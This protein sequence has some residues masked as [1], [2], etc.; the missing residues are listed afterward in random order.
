MGEVWHARDIT[1]LRAVAVK[2]LRS[3]FTDDDTFL[4][5][6]RVEAQNMASL[7]HLNIAHVHDYGEAMAEG[8]HV[9][10]LVM[11][12]VDGQ[13]LSAIL[14]GQERPDTRRVLDILGQTAAGLGAAHSSGVVH[15]D[16]KPGN[17]I[18]RPDGTVK[19]T[20]FG[21]SRATD[22]VPLTRSGMVVGTA[23]YLS[24]EQAMGRAV[25]PASDVYAL[26]V[27]GYECLAGH[28]PFQA[29]SSVAV[30]LAHVNQDPPPLPNEIPSVIRALVLRAMSK[31]PADRF[32][33]GDA[34][35]AA[36]QTV[37]DEQ[38]SLT[39]VNRDPV[40]VPPSEADVP[41]ADDMAAPLADE[42][43]TAEM[44]AVLAALTSSR[45]TD[46]D[47]PPALSALSRDKPRHR[48]RL[49]VLALV[50]ALLVAGAVTFMV[51]KQPEGAANASG[52]PTSTGPELVLVDTAAYV[53]RPIDE[54]EAE[55]TALGLVVVR[56]PVEVSGQVLQA[57]GL[58]DQPFAQ[59]AVLGTDPAQAEVPP[60]T[61]VTVSFAAQA[62][63]PRG[64]IGSGGGGADNS[65][66]TP[67]P[68]ATQT[69][70]QTQT[71]RPRPHPTRTPP[72]APT[73]TPAPSPTPDPTPTPT[74]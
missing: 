10:Y 4:A 29:E 73:T 50:A 15:R 71:P 36:I 72:P 51:T 1:L 24:P 32:S 65:T 11:E 47:D 69:Q 40:P 12:M 22:H 58:Q 41:A 27:V 31:D 20:D 19:I 66:P 43:T 35:A 48:R 67:T 70:T 14:A 44:P 7:S 5:R 74:P 56:N 17:L 64:G 63:Q 68:S 23:L 38:M 55:L 9:A 45:F 46:T 54:V 53:G 16:V 8:E 26:G 62:Y 30:A 2:V 52:A 37:T 57:A 42:P 49:S 61:S 59:N 60:G 6:F 33:D 21:I 25:T 28:R 13:P 34:F 39:Q 3:E 18:V